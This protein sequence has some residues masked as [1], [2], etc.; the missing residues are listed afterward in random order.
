MQAALARAV[1]QLD[2][3]SLRK[4]PTAS[5]RPVNPL[6]NVLGYADDDD[7]D[8]EGTDIDAEHNTAAAADSQS[9]DDSDPLAGFLSELQNEGLLDTADQDVPEAT[10]AACRR[11]YRSRSARSA[12]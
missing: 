5:A 3:E 8:D 6:A 11:L 9:H 7:D 2:N 12:W 4:A 1:Q 10:G